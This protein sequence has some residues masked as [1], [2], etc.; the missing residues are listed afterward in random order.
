MRSP[1]FLGQ[2]KKR[3]KNVSPTFL[4]SDGEKTEILLILIQKHM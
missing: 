2:E 1:A 4:D 3:E